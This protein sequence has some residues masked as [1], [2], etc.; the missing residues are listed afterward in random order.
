MRVGQAFRANVLLRKH[1]R[2]R[3]GAGPRSLRPDNQFFARFFTGVV[4]AAV[5]GFVGGMGVGLYNDCCRGDADYEE[6]A[7]VLAQFSLGVCSLLGAIGGV[8]AGIA[9]Y[10]FRRRW[11]IVSLSSLVVLVGWHAMALR[12]GAG[13][14]WPIWLVGMESGT[15]AASLPCKPCPRTP[16][17]SFS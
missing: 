4:V 5:I 10:V 2:T 15:V 11:Q 8:T 3:R 12:D 6:C 7:W 9:A 13:V 17:T 1:A 14:A 16:R